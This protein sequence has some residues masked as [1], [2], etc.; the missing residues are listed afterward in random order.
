L[1]TARVASKRLALGEAHLDEQQLVVELLQLGA[2]RAAQLDRLVEAARLDQQAGTARLE[3]L[4]QKRTLLCSRPRNRL[5]HKSQLNTGAAAAVALLLLLLLVVVELSTR[6]NS[7]ALS[8]T[9]R[10]NLAVFA[11]LSELR[12]G[13]ES[14]STRASDA[15]SRRATYASTRPRS[16]CSFN[17][18]ASDA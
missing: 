9:R 8:T 2:E 5:V 13:A 1:E 6:D 12:K 16:A 4:S 17:F 14:R 15:V 18:Q 3:T 11:L 10:T 7:P